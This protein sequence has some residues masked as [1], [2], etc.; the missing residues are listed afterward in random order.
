MKMIILHL[1]HVI[2][3]ERNAQRMY[4]KLQVVAYH[5]WP[6][7]LVVSGRRVLPRVN[8]FGLL[9]HYSPYAEYSPA[10]TISGVVERIGFQAYIY[11][12]I[13]LSNKTK[14]LLTQYAS[15]NT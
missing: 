2:N 9:L 10:S 4:S 13:R 6:G 5:N 8:N 7:M 3:R 11:G 12:Y 14:Q 15:T 1:S